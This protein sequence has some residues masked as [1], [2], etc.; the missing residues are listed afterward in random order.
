MARRALVIVL[1]LILAGF[2]YIGYTSYDAKR[3]EAS[4]AVF[5]KDPLPDGTTKTDTGASTGSKDRSAE[6]PVVNPPAA[7][8]PTQARSDNAVQ[9]AVNAGAEGTVNSDTISPNPPNG[10]VFSGSGHYQ[11]YRQGDL[12]WRVNTDT[13]Q[14]CILFA[15]D[16]EWKKAK[17]Y[18]NGCAKR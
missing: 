6:M 9:T 11:L 3:A 10:M 1:L 2:A 7:V 17:V 13:G 16:A 8:P 15:T 18:R 4:G 14:A 12:T 5:S